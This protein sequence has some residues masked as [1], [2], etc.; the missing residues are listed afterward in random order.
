MPWAARETWIETNGVR[1][2]VLEDGPPGGPLVIL[3]HGF[4]EFSYA[5]R[6]QGP[7]LAAA[8]FHVVAPDQR[9][10][11]QSDKPAG[12]RAYALDVL[13]AD[14][15][16]LADAYGATTFRL[17][18]HDWGAAV[19]WWV[20]IHHGE[21]LDRLAILNAPHP[22]AF[23]RLIRR[24][25]RQLARSWY[26]FVF[27]VPA[28]P[29]WSLRRNGMR[30]ATDSLV[31]SSRPGT[32]SGEDL[33]RYCDAWSQPGAWTSMINWYRAAGRRYSTVHAS[34]RVRVPVLILWGD[35][36]RFIESRAAGDSLALCE[37]GRL[38]RFP[39]ATHWIHLEEPGRV[40]EELTRF[41]A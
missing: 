15:I 10:Y 6:H 41:L 37:Q 22:V 32:F 9:G 7:A 16:G 26:M 4:P 24:S 34:P 31:A 2:H 21:R 20:A 8:G 33:A 39:E 18:G 36:D 19:A 5:W 13:A 35:R 27:Q 29:E 28:L 17:V 11:A 40:S 25:P 30:A 14:I 1:L 23:Q 12:V 3:L 38:V